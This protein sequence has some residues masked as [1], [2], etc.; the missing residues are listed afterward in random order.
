MRR[1]LAILLLA[2]LPLQFSW[3]AVAGYCLHEADAKA[4]HLGHHE[5]E[6]GHDAGAEKSLGAADLDCEQCHGSCIA[7]PQLMP[8]A[9]V[10]ALSP[11]P[12]H[13]AAP[14]TTPTAADR[15]ERPQWAGL[16]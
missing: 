16:A 1:C 14:R 15:P 5:H 13:E 7:L 3:A 11:R 10:F 4:W 8:T 2:L 9:D 6:H 12:L